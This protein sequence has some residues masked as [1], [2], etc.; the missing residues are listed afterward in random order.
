MAFSEFT[1]IE[2]TVSAIQLSNATQADIIAA[3]TAEAGNG[4]L[5]K[6]TMEY[7]NNDR[8]YHITF[9][10]K[11]STVDLNLNPTDWLVKLNT[12]NYTVMTNAEFETT[13][14]NTSV[15]PI[16]PVKVGVMEHFLNLANK[17]LPKATD[18]LTLEVMKDLFEADAVKSWYN[19]DTNVMSL[20]FVNAGIVDP[21]GLATVMAMI[22]VA[23]YMKADTAFALNFCNNVVSEAEPNK[24]QFNK[25]ALQLLE[26]ELRTCVNMKEIEEINF[27][28]M[29]DAPSAIAP[30]V[31]EEQWQEFV[32]SFNK[33]TGAPVSNF[34]K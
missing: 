1:H 4:F 25:I 32:L 10:Y 28:G 33:I 30:S 22:P 23:S 21:Q 5:S 11:T 2:E 24:N 8:C 12:G 26:G 27:S 6:L 14:V 17:V 9:R 34:K 16:I 13:Y 29:N 19:A 18:K 31:T 15:D 3:I 7:V 20:R